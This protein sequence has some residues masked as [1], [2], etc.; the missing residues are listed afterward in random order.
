MSL[1]S[2]VQTII[3]ATLGWFVGKPGTPEWCPVIAW[4]I[5]T[6]G[7]PLPVTPHGARR[8]APVFYRDDDWHWPPRVAAGDV[9]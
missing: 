7:A 3:P 4:A 9:G 6:E 2:Q 1:P 8:N 5:L